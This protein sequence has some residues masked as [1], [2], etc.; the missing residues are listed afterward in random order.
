MRVE[1]HQEIER[2]NLNARFREWSRLI[3]LTGIAQVLVQAIGFVCGILVIR[4]L[5]VHEYALYTLAN[6]MLGTMTI[7]AD[8]G[9]ASGV[10]AE[11]GRIWQDKGKLGA[12][13]ATGMAL[14]KKFVIFSLLVS[15]PILFYLLRKH[16]ASWLMSTM[17]ALS[18]IPA[19][20][21]ALS[22]TLL[23]I[24]PKLH[25]D[26][27]PMQVYQVEANSGRLA[28]T[29]LTLFVF[30]YAA[31]AICC[32]GISQVWNNLRLKKLSSRHASKHGQ[33]DY[34]AQERI[35][36]MM[37]TL[38]PSSLYYCLSEHLSIWLISILG[39]SVALAQVG[40]LGRFSAVLAV[41]QSVLA[42]ILIPRFARSKESV[43]VMLGMF[44]KI[45]LLLLSLAAVI[46]LCVSIWPDWPLK[47]LGKGYEELHLGL[48]ISIAGGCMSF[49]SMTTHLLLTGR[50]LVIP[51]RLFISFSVLSQ[52]LY[53]LLLKPSD[54]N[55]VLLFSLLSIASV[56][57]LRLVYF[58]VYVKK[59]AHI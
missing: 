53:F 42:I 43:Q 35:K 56:Y 21:S 57:L 5:P 41:V 19:F 36:Q 38:Y 22:G 8:G 11:G 25:Q 29:A 16:D 13:L 59:H 31:V 26:I 7:L 37:R 52:C 10:M 12:V 2:T 34:D 3:L 44:I 45:Q 20:L 50:G 40:A 46:T 49:V 28:L 58:M 33:I 17:I 23:Q 24:P 47:I 4:L 6:T 48:A 27:K 55:S 54:V 9:I 18:L 32:A 39:S 30:P 14:R 51:A 1:L 15:I